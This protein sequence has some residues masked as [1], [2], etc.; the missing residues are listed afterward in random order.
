MLGI[1]RAAAVAEE[2]QLA[3][4]ADRL[5]AGADQAGE[6]GGQRRFGA[7]LHVVM[8]GEFGFEKSC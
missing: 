6:G 8:L 2:H 1:S 7:P 5:D 4:A 3:A